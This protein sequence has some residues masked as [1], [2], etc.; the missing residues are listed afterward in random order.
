MTK[1]KVNVDS[2]QCFFNGCKAAHDLAF[3]E[4]INLVVQNNY[5]ESNMDAIKSL[6]RT[7]SKSKLPLRVCFK[8]S[9]NSNVNMQMSK[10]KQYYELFFSVCMFILVSS[11][12]RLKN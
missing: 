6:N 10:S 8:K 9:Q 7:L 1:K 3:G 11:L 12:K 5:A 4:P 2:S